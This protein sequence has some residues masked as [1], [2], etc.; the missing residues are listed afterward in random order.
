MP[1]V[2]E[3]F[4]E[5]FGRKSLIDELIAEISK[6]ERSSILWICAEIVCQVQLWARPGVRNRANYGRYLQELFEP[7]VSQRLI[8]GQ[9]SVLPY[10]FAFH[11]RQIDLVAKIALEFGGGGLDAL[12]HRGQLGVLFLMANDHL[13][14]GLLQNAPPGIDAREAAIPLIV[15]MLAV[16]EGASPAISNLFTRGHLMLTRY[17]QEL[18]GAHD[19]VDV[20]G[21]FERKIGLSLSEFEAIVFAV[22][23]RFGAG[24]SNT[25]VANPALLPLKPGD[26]VTTALAPAK[27]EA[28]LKFVS[29]SPEDLKKE[30]QQSNNG[31]NDATPFVSIRWCGMWTLELSTRRKPI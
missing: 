30:I 19:F 31:P 3:S 22:H 16:Q 13:D 6:Y 26:F 29:V 18:A 24:M 1:A 28:F 4:E 14:H 23:A 8:A 25:V 9:R 20:A 15:E 5:I 7:T 27:V 10:R 2:Y 21:E 11:R 12:E 17:A